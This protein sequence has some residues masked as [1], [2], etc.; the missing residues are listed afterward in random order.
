ME[1]IVIPLVSIVIPVYNVE[2]YLRKCLDSICLQT[3]K[4]LEI[5]VVDDGSPDNS[6]QIYEEFAARD[7][8]I[9]VIHKENGGL[10]DA[11]NA[12]LP[13]CRGEYL[14]FVDS[15]DYLELHA[16]ERMLAAAQ[17][18][19]A[20]IVIAS[21]YQEYGDQKTPYL[22]CRPSGLYEGEA[23]RSIAIDLLTDNRPTRIRPYVWSRLI[24]R[25]LLE[26]PPLVFDT[27]LKRSEDFLFSCLL[28]FRAKRVFLLGGEPL[29]HY[30]KAPASTSLS[31]RYH[32]RFWDMCKITYHRLNSELSSDSRLRPQLQAMLIQRSLLA[33]YNAAMAPSQSI[34]LADCRQILADPDLLLAARK[35]GLVRN[36]HRARI[37]SLLLLLR[38]RR[39]IVFLFGR[40]KSHA[41]KSK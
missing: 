27:N 29:Y 31:N 8:R 20:D 9:R 11:R 33:L 3:W 25:D 24:R 4:H 22:Y 6:R 35:V 17:E 39:V 26:N 32:P 23:C 34:F 1:S 7:P 12:A 14:L 10:S 5:I 2:K 16:V 38:L 18:H 37:Y 13:F 41:I 15:D 21:F 40:I 28:H 36:S 30:I 19:Q